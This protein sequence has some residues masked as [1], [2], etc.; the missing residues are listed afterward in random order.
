MQN[1][2]HELTRKEWLIIAAIMLSLSYIIVIR[3]LIRDWFKNITRKKGE[4]R[5]WTIKEDPHS[6]GVTDSEEY[7]VDENEIEEEDEE[8]D[9]VTPEEEDSFKELELLAADIER[10]LSEKNQDRHDT[11]GNSSE[12]NPYLY[13]TKQA[14]ISRGYQQSDHSQ[15]ETTVFIDYH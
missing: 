6:E 3:I 5:V 9:S 8:D 13:G 11:Y 2:L 7:I 4:R 12:C 15:S 10:I 14:A 1:I